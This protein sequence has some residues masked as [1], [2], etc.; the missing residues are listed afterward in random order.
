MHRC[1]NINAYMH[2]CWCMYAIISYGCDACNIDASRNIIFM[3]QYCYIDAKLLMHQMQQ[4]YFIGATTYVHGAKIVYVSM[5]LK[6]DMS[7]WDYIRNPLMVVKK[8]VAVDFWEKMKVWGLMF[9]VQEA[10]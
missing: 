6:L 3:Q 9:W 7:E 5:Q 8:L 4:Y 2:Q 1:Y 10:E